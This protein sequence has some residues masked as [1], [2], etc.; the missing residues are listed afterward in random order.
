M[1]NIPIWP[2]SSSFDSGSGET[3]F[4]FYDSDADF[5]SDIDKVT[6]FVT[7]RL[8]YPITDAEL[9][10][11][12]IYTCFEEAVTTYG[13]EVY[14]WKIENDYLSLEGSPTTT[15]LNNQLVSPNM[16]MIIR[17]SEQ[18]GSEAGTGG[19]LEWYTGSIALT[20][21]VQDYNLEAWATGQ[22]ITAG[23]MEIKRI[24][25]QENPAIVRFFDPYAGTGTGV[26][27]LLESFG[28]GNFSPGINFLLMPISYDVQKLQAI[29]L[30]DQVRKSNFSFE[31]K[32]NK[33]RI[34][35]IPLQDG[36][37]HFEYVLKSER[38]IVATETSGSVVTDIS[39]VPYENPTYASI[40]SVGRSWI[41]RYTLALVKETL[42]YIRGKYQTVPVP[43]SETTLN[44]AQLLADAA[45][46][47]DKLLENLRDM[48][49][50]VSRKSQLEKRAQE[51]E[52]LQKE[53]NNV[54]LTIY[55]K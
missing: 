42:G 32:N 17:I 5:Q 25:Y 45:N 53:L 31:L 33:L 19:K 51:T 9:Q 2:G 11:I 38:S 6:V 10:E 54:P 47:K 41:Y 15:T 40:N 28:F 37:L 14:L 34:F 46:E 21:S 44:H 36:R 49:E 18:Y 30:N 43:G 48:L 52:Y 22:G 55:V 8:G 29:E 35:P 24:F 1:A 7:R 3:P 50:R 27:T 39:N 4:G 13:N 26:Q 12:N 16:G 20:Q 23:D